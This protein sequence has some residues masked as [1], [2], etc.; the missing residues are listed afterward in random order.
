MKI[1]GKKRIIGISAMWVL[2]MGAGLVWAQVDTKTSDQNHNLMASIEAHDAQGVK[3][4]ITRSYDIR[5][6]SLLFVTPLHVVTKGPDR[7]LTTRL[8]DQTTA[9]RGMVNR[10]H[11]SVHAANVVSPG[12]QPSFKNSPFFVV[13]RN[14][15]VDARVKDRIV[16]TRTTDTAAQVP[17]VYKSSPLY[18]VGFLDPR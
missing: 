12:Q 1:S 8:Y 16:M 7:E 14:N 17:N 15:S 4:S 5:N 6:S 9:Q 3:Q 2:L 11:N 18:V 10:Q 13:T